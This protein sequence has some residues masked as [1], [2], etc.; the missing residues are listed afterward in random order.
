MN[1][2]AERILDCFPSGNYALSALLR[3]VDIVET[4]QVPTAAVEC[5]AQPR[6]L[7]NPEFVDSYAQTPEKLLMLVMHELHH[8]LLGHTT[9]F[10][11]ATPLQNFVFDCVIN[12][13]I[14]RMFPAPEH[15]A[16][17]TG[18]YDAARFPE[19]LLRPP[20]GWSAD[21][22]GQMPIGI[23]QPGLPK[24]TRIAEIYHALYAPAGATYKEIF[25]ILPKCLGDASVAGVPL[26]GG[27]EGDSTAGALE[28]RSPVLFDVVREAV[29]RWPQPPD[30]IRGRSLADVLKES[31]VKINNKPDKRSILRH[32]L[33]KVGGRDGQGSIHRVRPDAGPVSTPIP[34][35]DRR[36]GVLNA[37]GVKTMLYT[38]QTLWPRRVRTGDKVHVYVD[39]SGSMSGLEGAIYGAILDCRQ[40]VHPEV[41]LFSTAVKDISHQA[42]RRGMVQS[43][44]GT[45]IDCVAR[46]MHQY[47][48]RR[49][50]IITDGWVGKPA[51]TFLKTLTAVRLAVAWA[52]KDA[53]LNDLKSVANYTAHLPI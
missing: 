44:G 37:L 3:L 26:L 35:M 14:S 4:D 36:A 49:A 41:H 42:I 13:L 34:T 23:A 11:T 27:H 47:R 1:S 30:P 39:V 17:L 43:T 20:P 50:C 25:D 51:G 10:P 38:G 7:V 19:C 18:F 6:M 29:E 40:W 21:K 5:R 52:G 28:H 53:N 46:H 22:A 24:M 48:I 31:T 16:F 12:A 33:Q 32:L 9:L 15:T 2:I 8:V 45:D